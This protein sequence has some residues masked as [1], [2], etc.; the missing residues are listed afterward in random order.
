MLVGMA[1]TFAIVATLAAVGGGWAVRA[2]EIGRWLALG[3]LALFGLALLFPALSDRLTRPLVA[4]GSR[5]SEKA[6]KP[7]GGSGIGASLLLGVATGLL[8][9]PC[10]GPILGIIFTAAALN[11]ASANTTLLLL[12]YALGAA[13]SLALALLVGGKV[14]AR[15]KKSLGIAEWVRKVLGVLVLVGVL[16]IALGLDTRVLSKLSTAQTSGLE[17]GLARTLGVDGATPD[18]N[19]NNSGSLDLP[20]EGVMPP[21][22]GIT[23]WINSPPLTRE[24]LK[25]KVVVIDFWTYSCINCIR[26]LP[27]VRAWYDRYKDDGLVVIGVHAPE[28]AFEKNPD[29]VRKAVADLGIEYPVALDNNYAVWRAFNNRFWPAHYFIDAKGRI[30]YHHFGE[31]NYAE[32]EQV[33]RK[34]L[35]EAGYT[36]DAASSGPI[37]ASGAEAAAA[38][39]SLNSP[40]TY[41]GY[42]RAERFASPGGLRKDQASDYRLAPL[43]LN[44]WALEGKWTVAPQS[45]T[46]I[47][48]PGSISYRFHA[49][50]LHLVMGAPDGKPVRFKV[51]IDGKA[52]GADAGTD[53]DASG[54]GTV[55]NERLYQLVRQQGPVRDRTFRITFLDPGVKAFAF[56]FG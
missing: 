47:A 49:R 33:I 44:Q 39:Q 22:T 56:T 42:A 26:S 4:W 43:K 19:A 25:G 21:L 40:E 37:G 36:P 27:Y 23:E 24:Q 7:G 15:M 12:A 8:W 31:G 13:T 9:A 20:V 18:Q 48:A 10:A 52:P 51:T 30:R 55:T 28:F 17:S 29:N 11:G 38:M 46:L 53:V 50:D 45:A 16:A 5:L 14:F 1:L 35:K 3:L 6:D 54:N 2:N 32:S 41:V 34:L